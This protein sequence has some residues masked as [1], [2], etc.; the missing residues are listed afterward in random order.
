[1]LFKAKPQGF[2]YQQAHQQRKNAF[3]DAS[4][5]GN[6]KHI[7]ACEL[8]LVALEYL[9]LTEVLFFLVTLTISVAQ[10][11]L[12]IFKVTFFRML[13]DKGVRKAKKTLGHSL[14]N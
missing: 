7:F 2:L 5:K 13:S 6:N 14:K 4:V 10:F 8:T 3:K 11:V 1:M 9:H 12:E